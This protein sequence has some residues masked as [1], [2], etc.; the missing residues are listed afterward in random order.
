MANQQLMEFVTQR[1]VKEDEV[2]SLIA[3]IRENLVFVWTEAVER[4]N[5]LPEDDRARLSE[6][7]ILPAIIRFGYSQSFAKEKFQGRENEGI[8]ECDALQVF[9]FYV[10]D[11]ILLR[12]NSVDRKH[13]VL[14]VDGDDG[15]ET[16][17]RQEPMPGIDSNATR[18]TCGYMMDAAKANLV[19]VVISC[20]VGEDCH[21]WFPIDNAEMQ[22]LPLPGPTKT[23]EPQD[24]GHRLTKTKRK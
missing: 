5:S 24:I 7:G 20:Q 17:F 8:V 21:Y 13:V 15:K 2:R 23:P 6:W 11:K 4:W 1:L 18:L 10:R 3:P 16:Y 22:V 19:S 9:T 14:N 12:F